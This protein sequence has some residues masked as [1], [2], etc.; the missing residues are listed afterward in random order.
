MSKKLDCVSFIFYM[1]GG[2]T[3]LQHNPDTPGVPLTRSISYNTGRWVHIL[4]LVY[5]DHTVHTWAW[6]PSARSTKD[7]N[8][9]TFYRPLASGHPPSCTTMLAHH[10]RHECHS[11]EVCA[12][13]VAKP[14]R[15]A[16]LYACQESGVAIRTMPY[17]V[18]RIKLSSHRAAQRACRAGKF[19]AGRR[20]VVSDRGARVLGAG[21]K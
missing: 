12:R 8:H 2:F 14:A 10:R 5:A 20:D 9:T 16:R 15:N 19:R 7:V 21:V 1:I 3:S 11:D 18:L 17:A 6:V 4:G 13:R